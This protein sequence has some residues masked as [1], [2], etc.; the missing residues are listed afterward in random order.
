MVVI[1]MLVMTIIF[2][3]WPS[4]QGFW[5]LRVGAEDYFSI[6]GLEKYEGQALT[7]PSLLTWEATVNMLDVKFCYTIKWLVYK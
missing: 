2:V 1:E 7:Y 6:P 3:D 5:R 4:C